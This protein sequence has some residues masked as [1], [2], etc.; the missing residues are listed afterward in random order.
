MR[1]LGSLAAFSLLFVACC[2]ARCAPAE[3]HLVR[4]RS[5]PAPIAARPNASS[6]FDFVQVTDGAQVFSAGG[7][8]VLSMGEIA[9]VDGSA[10]PG[11]RMLHTENSDGVQ[12]IIGIRLGQA[13]AAGPVTLK[14]WLSTSADPYE[15]FIDHVR[16]SSVPTALPPQ[17]AS[18][19]TRHVLEISL[20]DDAHVD[21]NELKAMILFEIEKN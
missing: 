8:G 12:T 20:P 1:F 4:L 21:E 18:D 7:A 6:D 16:L 17:D 11:V 3:Q 14:A 2:S 10:T 19:I 13:A 5:A 15:V 9:P